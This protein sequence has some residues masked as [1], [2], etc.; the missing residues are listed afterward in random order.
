MVQEFGLP[1]DGNISTGFKGS[2]G[3]KGLNQPWIYQPVSE[4]NE[5]EPRFKTSKNRF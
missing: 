4:F 2:E 3:L 1:V 5:F